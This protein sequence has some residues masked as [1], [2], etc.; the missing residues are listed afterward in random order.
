[1][2]KQSGN[3]ILT[4]P[5]LIAIG[6]I[7]IAILTVTT[8]KILMPYI[9]YE[10][11]SSTCIKYVFVIE[12]YGYLTKKETKLLIDELEKEGFEREKIKLEYTSKAVNY[13]DEIYLKI[14]YDY[15]LKIP[16]IGEKTIPMQI[17]KYSICKR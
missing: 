5:L 13:G 12:E 3:A 8:I 15:N 17:E 1:M 9:W 7:L 14:K 11:L 10:K 16:M 6:T 4:T 2:K